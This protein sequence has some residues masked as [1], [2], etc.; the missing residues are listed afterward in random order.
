MTPGAAG[1][2]NI[3]QADPYLQE[4]LHEARLLLKQA[5]IEKNDATKSS[6]DMA[7]ELQGAKRELA[8]ANN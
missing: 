4:E 5:N 8:T 1:D 6:H 2:V 3:N 7:I